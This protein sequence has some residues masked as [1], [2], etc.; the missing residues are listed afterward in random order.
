MASPDGRTIEDEITAANSG[1][2]DDNVYEIKYNPAENSMVVSTQH[3][4][5]EF[6]IAGAAAGSSDAKKVNVY[7]NPVRPDYLGWVT[8]EDLPSN[9]IVKITDAMGNLVKELGFAENG[10]IR[11]DVTNSE[12]KRV[13]SGVYHIFTSSADEGDSAA[14]VG[15]IL[16]VN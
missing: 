14:P 6:R 1:L 7:P 10:S 16:V 9:A 13:K 11:W 2:P 4:I 12:M 5:A 8:I 15:K 3:G